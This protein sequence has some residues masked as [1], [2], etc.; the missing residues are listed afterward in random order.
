[1]RTVSSAGAKVFLFFQAKMG[2]ELGIA[3][4]D[5][6]PEMSFDVTLV[7]AAFVGDTLVLGRYG[8]FEVQTMDFHGS[9]RSA[10]K[11]LQSGLDLH[12]RDFPAVLR[13]NLEW[14]GR[15]IEG[16]NVANVFKRTFYQIILK[17]SLAG[18]AD[19]AGVALGL[20]S[21]VWRSW[22][23]HFGGPSFKRNK[24]ID[25]MKGS[26]R[27]GPKSSWILV[28]GS[29]RSSG[30]SPEHISVDRTIHV[31]PRS[32]LKAAFDD[33]PAAIERNSTQGIRTLILA[34]MRTIYPKT[35]YRPR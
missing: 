26:G 3:G 28:F 22:H 35:E 25:M 1:M 15:E 31:S 5:V 13:G 32:L 21:A 6:S 27:T 2:G 24:G 9:Y 10:V 18:H 29:R 19:C 34:R 8:I 33:V 20:P 23:P 4:T 11:A 14:A 30:G 7:P 16:P 12:G 17:F